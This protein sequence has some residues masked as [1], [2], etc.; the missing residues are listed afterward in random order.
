MAYFFF[1]QAED[2]I[3][4]HCVTGVQTCALPI[5]RSLACL[6]RSALPTRSGTIWVS[7]G[8]TGRPAAVSAA[9]VWVTARCCASRSAEDAF[10]W[11]I[12]VTAAAA[13]AGGS[14]VVKMKPGA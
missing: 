12:E 5:W 10:R 6:Q 2:G 9:L 3:R 14:A 1:F 8:M 13:M 4:D 7:D 11:R